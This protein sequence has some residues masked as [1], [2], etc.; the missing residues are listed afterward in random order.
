MKKTILV[1]LAVLSVGV[2]TSKAGVAFSVSFGNSHR[3]YAPV[4]AAPVCATPVYVAPAPVYR[5]VYRPV[6]QPVYPQPVY[7]PVY[8]QPVYAPVCPPTVVVQPRYHGGYGH[9]YPRQ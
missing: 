3:H 8:Q 5:P 2:A 9:S 1:A 6:Y 4:Y 7:A